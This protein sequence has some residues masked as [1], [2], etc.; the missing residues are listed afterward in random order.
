M[1][2]LLILGCVLLALA[3]VAV[4][5]GTPA[6]TAPVVADSAVAPA[7]EP[8]AEPVA[9]PADAEVAEVKS[10]GQRRIE[11]L[12][13]VNRRLRA[14]LAALPEP[15]KEP[16]PE[17]QRPRDQQGRF[18]APE[19]PA[20]AGFQQD[21]DGNLFFRGEW[22]T[23]DYV[24]GA[25]GDAQSAREALDE[26]RQLR[27]ERKREAAEARTAA[28]QQ[29]IAEQHGTVLQAAEATLTEMVAKTY[30]KLDA[31]TL[32]DA[33]ETAVQFAAAHVR[34]AINGNLD[35]LTAEILTEG[36]DFGM[37]RVDRMLRA[38]YAQQVKSN[39]EHAEANRIRSG[40][41]GPGVPVKHLDQMTTTEIDM[42]IQRASETAKARRVAER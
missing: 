41:G 22:H 14:Q 10:R 2:M 42:A 25:L 1:L 32:T 38:G 27:D 29:A 15:V 17:P 35:N 30:S 20:L 4:A 18:A 37:K 26:V 19:D 6:E 5:E 34:G 16:T 23:P 28:D 31:E 11:G 12:L 24:K 21:A 7:G 33:Q 39:E 8:T 3:E 40:Q 36:M 13:T 9:E